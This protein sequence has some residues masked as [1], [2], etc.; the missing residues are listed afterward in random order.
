MLG[1]SSAPRPSLND[2]Y[3]HDTVRFLFRSLDNEDDFKKFCEEG[4]KILKAYM[5]ED[6]K[7]LVLD[8]A[9]SVSPGFLTH[10]GS[11]AL[12]SVMASFALIALTV[13]LVSGYEGPTVFLH[14]IGEYLVRHFPLPSSP[15]S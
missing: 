15:S 8:V 13:I 9:K 5:E 10:L 4:E 14:G 3:S 12:F 7:I 2:V 1:A 11:H 6:L